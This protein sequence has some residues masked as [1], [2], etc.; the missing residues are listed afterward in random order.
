VSRRD[1][2]V[3]GGA[4]AVVSAA[5]PWDEERMADHQLADALAAHLPVLYV[6]PCTS[7]AARVRDR[8]VRAVRQTRLTRATDRLVVMRPEGIPGLS[9]P[10]VAPTNRRFVAAQIRAALRRLGCHALVVIEANLLT[11][12]IGL[13]PATRKVY[14]AQ[15][16]FVGMAPLVGV[17]E[18]VYVEAEHTVLA[19]ADQCI[20]AN[21]EIA[22]RLRREGHQVELIP[23]GC[24]FQLF[25]SSRSAAPATDFALRRPIA[26][27]MGTLNDRID[28]EI[29][30]A[31]AAEEVSLLL[32]GPRG[33]RETEERFDQLLSLP[34]VA[35]VG[36][37]DF[38]TLP[39][40]L[41]AADVALVPYTHSRFNEGSFP[42]KTLE[43]L[44]AGLP[45]VATDLPAIRWLNSPDVHVAD[46]PGSFAAEVTRLGRSVRSEADLD[47][48]AEFA[49]KHSW[50]GR[51]Q[52]F[53]EAI[54]IKA[55][56]VLT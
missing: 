23:F 26:V 38:R 40:Y 41:A 31:V 29:L 49:R 27:L 4:I 8:G 1:I 45:V 42:L 6:D 35:W 17:D 36:P 19:H 2:S 55:P 28:P 44:A 14:W 47:R 22:D 50:T 24:D 51:A 3:P 53:A 43:Y 13:V 54:G 46:D 10:R 20:A 5:N 18:A 56:G 32:I 30:A 9:H 12:V 34:N 48:R 7:V 15:D 33:A 16:D 21:P 52:A 39:G 37:K 11:P 25:S